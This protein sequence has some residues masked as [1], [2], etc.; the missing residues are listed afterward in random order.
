MKHKINT[1]RHWQ[2]E[3]RCAIPSSR[4][5]KSVAQACGHLRVSVRKWGR[6]KVATDQHRMWR[7]IDM[8]LECRDLLGL[9]FERV[10]K[11]GEYLREL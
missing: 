6:I 7:G 5:Y 1:H 10:V 3:E 11:F 2:G 4:L 9:L 8:S